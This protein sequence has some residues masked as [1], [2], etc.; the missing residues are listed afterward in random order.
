MNQVIAI[1]KNNACFYYINEKDIQKYDLELYDHVVE[2]L[3][4]QYDSYK[5]KFFTVITTKSEKFDVFSNFS[6][7]K[8]YNLCS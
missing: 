6:A 5:R 4:A 1:T 2:K 3:E 7:R 8:H